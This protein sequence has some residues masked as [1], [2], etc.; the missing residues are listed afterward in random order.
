LTAE[1]DQQADERV[2]ETHQLDK[3]EDQRVL[4]ATTDWNG[5]MSERPQRLLAMINASAL[6]DILSMA[7]TIELMTTAMQ[8]ISNGFVDAPE[9]RALPIASN[10]QLVLMPGAM[11]HIG[12]FGVKVLSL[13]SAAANY[14]LPGH[15]GVMLL[16]DLATGRPLCVLESHSVTALRTAAASAVATRTLARSDSRVLALIG[17]GA[18][19]KPH[20]EAISMVRDIDRIIVWGRSAQ[21]ARLFASQYSAHAKQK[22]VVADR[23][24]DAVQQA[25]IVCTI[26]NSPEPILEGKWLRAGQHLN[27]VGASTRFSREIDDF[28]VSIGRFV[29]DFRAHALAQAG[30]LHHAIETG[31]VGKDHIAAEIGE[32]LAGRAKGRTHRSE[33]TMYKSLGHAAQDLRVAD[34]VFHR[35]DRSSHVVNVNW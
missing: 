9:R 22:I 6:A 21:K 28:A 7:D 35:L 32:I 8:D 24:E 17:C 23:V 25:D 14:G 13:S 16:F 10:Q 20:A 12:R 1:N 30:E 2:F 31:H 29:V 18:L 4:P 3:H 11:A 34:A 33:I 26:T 5:A 15:Q 27:L 19:A